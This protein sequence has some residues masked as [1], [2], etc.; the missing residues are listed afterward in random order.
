MV[1]I[2]AR[3]TIVDLLVVSGLADSRGSARRTVEEGGASVNNVKITDEQWSPVEQ[4]LL[5][6]RWLMV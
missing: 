3:L 1:R 6:G 4:D 5:D 2:D